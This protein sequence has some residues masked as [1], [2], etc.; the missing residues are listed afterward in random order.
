MRKLFY[1]SITLFVFYSCTSKAQNQLQPH[2]G[3]VAVEG[4]EIW[5]KVMGEGEGIPILT[6]HGGPGG[7]HR[8]F[9]NLS[10]QTSERPIILFDQL[11][12]G[13]SDHHQDTSLMT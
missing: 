10:P 4:G 9:Y 11:G 7:T 8:Y 6:L 5:Y 13:R 3:T 1:L 12:S 2:E